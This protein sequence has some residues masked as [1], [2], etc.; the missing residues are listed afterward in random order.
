MKISKRIISVL[1][2][3]PILFSLLVFQPAAL[4]SGAA[5]QA[6]YAWTINYYEKGTAKA[7]IPPTTGSS[8]Q[9]GYVL[10]VY[11]ETVPG[12]YLDPFDQSPVSLTLTDPMTVFNFYYTP[13][14]YTLNFESNGGTAVAS[15]T[16]S[17]R[18]LIQRPSPNPTRENYN[19]TGWYK[20]AA[21]TLSVEWPY[22]MPYQG[23]TLYAGWQ[24]NPVVLTFNSNNGSPVDPMWTYPGLS[25]EKPNDPTRLNFVFEGWYYDSTFV[26]AV[27][28]PLV[29]PAHNIDLIAK[30]SFVAYTVTF[31][32]N[33]GTRV[34]PI[35]V[36]PGGKVYPPPEPFRTGYTFD[37]WYYDNDSFQNPVQ[38]PVIPSEQGFTVYAKWQPKMITI[39][40]DS[41]GGTELEPLVALAG[42]PISQPPSP[43]KFGFTFARWLIG[44]EP[45][46]WGNMPAENTTLTASWNASQR[47]AQVKLDTYKLVG[48]TLLPIDKARPGDE[49]VVTLTAGTNFFT[50]SSRFI[51]MYDPEFYQVVGAN[52]GAIH[53]NDQNN[54][55]ANAIGDYSG[56]TV[57]PASAWPPTFTEGESTAFKFI[58]ANFTANSNAQNGGKPLRIDN[59]THLFYVKFKVR[60]DAQGSGRVWMDSRWD[61][62]TSYP[63][64]G[65]YYFYCPNGNVYSSSGVSVLDFDTE[66]SGADKYINID[67]SPLPTSNI[68]FNSNGGSP[69]EI[70]NGVIGTEAHLPLPPAREGYTFAGWEPDFPAVFPEN[71]MVLTAQWNINTYKASF[72]VDG[73]QFW[74]ENY[75]YGAP[76]SPPPTEPTKEGHTFFAWS[77][78]IGNMAAGNMT[79]NAIFIAHWHDA[80]FMVDGEEYLRVSVEYGTPIPVPP[81]PLKEGHTFVAW[82]PA[83]GDDMPDHEVVFE[84][85][86]SINS[87]YANFEVDGDI[88][89]SVLVEYG[90]QITPPEDP[91]KYG[92][93]F[94]GWNPAVSTMGA[95]D[96][97]FVA[98]WQQ[99]IFDC[100]FMIDGEIFH[101]SPTREGEPIELPPTTPEKVGHDFLHWFNVPEVMPDHDI[102]IESRWAPRSYTITFMVD[103][104]QHGRTLTVLFGQAPPERGIPADPVKE[105]Y[106]F[107]GWS[108]LPATMPAE[109]LI[110]HAVFTPKKFN[111]NF[112]VE[113]ELHA[114]I[115][116]P[117][118]ADISFPE[119]P[120]KPG[121]VFTGWLDVPAAMPMHD[122]DLHASFAQAVYTITFVVDGVEVSEQS[123]PY[124]A[125]VTVPQAPEKEGHTF[126][127]WDPLVT[128]MPDYNVISYA[129][130]DKISY[131]VTFMV[132]GHVYE[133]V[134]TPYGSPIELPF[135]PYKEGYAF[136][137]WQGLP[138]HMP[139]QAVTVTALW[140]A[141]T[142]DAIFMVD[143]EDYAIV[144]TEFGSPISLPDS[145]KKTGF[146]FAGWTPSLPL[147]MPAY[148]I[149]FTA[150]WTEASEITLIAK[151]GSGTII[152]E[153]A[154][155]IYGLKA[156]I[157]QEEL[158]ED[159]LEVVGP[160][161]LRLTPLAAGFGSGSL[162]ELMSN[163][164]GLVKSYR[165]VIFGDT[166]GDGLVDNGDLADMIKIAGAQAAYPQSQ[167]LFLAMDLN[168]DGVIDAFDVNIL[169]AVLKGLAQLEQTGNFN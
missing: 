110:V 93:E 6:T 86:F 17:Y 3:F 78:V 15:V 31:N 85:V 26:Q 125:T 47:Y 168:A 129:L 16:Q 38:W 163:S 134:S 114:V 7:I 111:V 89:Y 58:A 135:T 35:T 20:D 107:E 51:M 142:Y 65:Q 52:K 147:S 154:G 117:V 118:G 66:Y 19:F 150:L 77:P 119:T 149:E 48:D 97:T 18:S 57:S 132:D 91:E 62:S 144:P 83:I 5:G 156:G 12:Y 143:G 148:S 68:I 32:S 155:L 124:G 145:P 152:D 2:V 115:E 160:G 113:G 69:V 10:N 42:S 50:G 120:E 123:L 43:N 116:T 151:E 159:Y 4:A 25:L 34:N 11:A 98:K 141:N 71:D 13:R 100:H 81:A 130:Y 60:E 106:D 166:N 59:D 36:A 75:E 169:K 30:W 55:F 140:Q 105:G 41:N 39:T 28:W 167:A 101:T 46:V 131:D 96:M 88:V 108:G 27:E 53:P 73:E 22:A 136:T 126:R 127:K 49:V 121:Y 133:V 56:S 161:Y 102:P 29:M 72:Y 112:Y 165:I 23:G 63:T 146:F 61:R 40:F 9:Y 164:G 103:G 54:Y 24:A 94:K 153:D 84:A 14:S 64:G 37:G 139:A 1:L 104:V 109:N 122:I 158:L 90:A 87:Y 128:V 70:L 67:E 99:V 44:S 138:D 95:A 45:F 157:S 80:V 137:G 162:V 21:C 33:G 76:I 8:S 92:F 74:E 82:Q 79:F